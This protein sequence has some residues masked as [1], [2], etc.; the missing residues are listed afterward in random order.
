MP[1]AE[2]ATEEI[3][4]AADAMIAIWNGA[5]LPWPEGICW[6]QLAGAALKAARAAR[7]QLPTHEGPAIRQ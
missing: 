6:L 7:S 2:I 5:R 1:E 3:T 4:A